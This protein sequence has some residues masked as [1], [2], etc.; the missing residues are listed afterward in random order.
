MLA[1][2][3]LQNS[4]GGVL[5]VSFESI[6]ECVEKEFQKLKETKNFTLDDI[7]KSSNRE[8]WSQLVAT[9][10]NNRVIPFLGAGMSCPIYKEWGAALQSLL[11]GNKEERDILNAFLE[12][13]K[14]EDAAEFVKSKTQ[15]LFIDR[16]QFE[17]GENRIGT[18]F[19]ETT[20][21]FVAK[22]FPNAPVFTTNFDRIAEKCYEYEGHPFGGSVYSLSNI[23]SAADLILGAVKDYKHYLFK[24]HGDVEQIGSWVFTKEQYNTAYNNSGFT[25]A[26]ET[27]SQYGTFL[28]LGCSCGG[29]DRY[30]GVFRTIVKS[31]NAN[32]CPVKHF[33]FL[34][35]P[36]HD[37]NTTQEAYA[38]KIERKERELGG[39]GVF[40]VWYPKGQY[41]AVRTLLRCLDAGEEN[42]FAV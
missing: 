42:V 13:N 6:M 10:K 31:T 26:L 5:M 36:E 18:R 8:R 21:S 2:V 19:G 14:Y 29:N 23:R 34:E 20:A 37:D 16:V 1:N 7:K 32:D 4:F 41:D 22:A 35:L 39:W 3:N 38:E 12:E 9:Y 25:S 17:F 33:A 27:I 28:F 40:P 30:A 11:Q 15:N 24:I